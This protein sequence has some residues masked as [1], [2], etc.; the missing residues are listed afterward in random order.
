MKE[1]GKEHTGAHK[2]EE[3]IQIGG[4]SI[5]ATAK[6]DY[7]VFV[8]DLDVCTDGTGDDH[9]DP[10]YQSETAYYN[11]GKFLNA[12]RDFYVVVPPQIRSMVP[13]TVMGC[14]AK[15]T[16][17]DTGKSHAAVV[18]DIGPDDKTGEAAICLAQFLNPEVSANSGD[19]RL[20]YFYECFPGK[21]AKVGNKTY[22]LEPA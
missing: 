7:V 20:I 11:G 5:Y 17:L 16:R 10:Y 4:V 2:L 18:G 3:L 15:L 22:K 12:D 1:R 21:P 9:G 14:Q 13:P 6:G 19:S 8:S